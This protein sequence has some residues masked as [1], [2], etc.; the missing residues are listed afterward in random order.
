MV[1]ENAKDNAGKPE[2]VYEGRPDIIGL[3][4][5]FGWLPSD[6]EEQDW[7]TLASLQERLVKADEEKSVQSW[8][9]QTRK[10]FN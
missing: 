5:R 6:A 3:S 7:A 2:R 9:A 8:Q 10:L 1:H 4:I